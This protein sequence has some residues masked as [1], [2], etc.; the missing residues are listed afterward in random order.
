MP[1][2]SLKTNRKKNIARKD[3]CFRILKR[4]SGFAVACFLVLS[5]SAFAAPVAVGTAVGAARGW[6]H[7][8]PRPLGVRL[9]SKV[10]IAEEVKS[11]AG[12]TLF[13]AVQLDP[14]GFVIIAADDSTDPV[15]VFTGV[16]AFHS[17]SNG[18]LADLVKRDMLRRI[19][20]ARTE[21]GAAS[22]LKSRRKWQALLRN[23]SGLTHFP[24]Q[25]PDSVEN[26]EGVASQIWIAPFVQT[27]WSQTTD[28]SGSNAC[29]NYFTPPYAAGDVD[30]YDCGCSATC[31][32]QEM[33][34]FRY[35]GVS[36]GTNSFTISNNGETQMAQLRG[37]D[38]A[39]GP[40]Q[41]GEM[42]L[43]PNYPTL[44]QASA[45]GSLTY[46][47]GV[48]INMA[49]GPYS[50]TAD[51]SLISRALTN[52][53]KFGN[54]V[55]CVGDLANTNWVTMI[56]PNLDAR[57]PVLLGLQGQ[58]GHV[59]VCD[60]YGYSASTL[61]HH[62]N[63]GWA[64]DDDI[65]YALPNVDTA[66][67]GDFSMVEE[68][69]YNI[70]TNG[71]GQIISGRVTVPSG[72]PLVGAAVTAVRN[73]GGNYQTTTDTNG[74]YA[75]VFV[76]ADSTYSLTA[77]KAGYATAAYYT[78]T[79]SS[80]ND[81]PASGNVWG[82]N[83]VLSPPL[84]VAPATGF[85][86]SG[87]PGGPF[88]VPSEIYT[89]TNAS[90]AP[91]NW[92]LSNDS[93]WLSVTPTS[94]LLAAGAFS[95]LTIALSPAVNNLFAG[96][97]S[98]SIW[99][100]NLNNRAAEEL[101]FSLAV[102]AG[103]APIAVTGY[104][105]DV[106]VQNTA[107]AGNST[108]YAE[109]FD[110]FFPFL[111]PPGPI[112]FYEAG[113]AATNLFGETAALG[114]PPGRLF[115][116]RVDNATTFQFGPY[117]ADNV[118]YLTT[119]AA[120]ASLAFNPPAAY[121]SLSVL[122]ASAQSGGDGTLVLQFSDGTA[123]SAIPFD[124]AN[125]LTT[126]GQ[127][128]NAAITNFGLLAV[129]DFGQFYSLNLFDGPTVTPSLFQ[130]SINLQD[131]AYDTNV[132]MSVLFTMPGGGEAT[133]N[134]VTGIFAL[135]GTETSFT[136][137]YPLTVGA[138]P[139]AGGTVSGGGIFAA[140]S[141]TTLTAVAS[142]AYSFADW[143]Q[144]G[145]AVSTSPIYTLVV[146]S[147]ETLV[148]NFLP[149]CLLTLT[150]FPA[151]SGTIGGGGPCPVGSYQTVMATPYSGFQFIGWS[152][153][154]SGTSNP[155]TIPVNQNMTITAN[156]AATGTAL[157]L[158]VTT[159]GN[160]TVLP[161]LNGQILQAGKNYTLTAT[162]AP[163]NLFSNWSG[164]ITTLQNPLTIKAESN[165]VLQAN[166]VPNPFTP[167]TG[168]Y[169][170]L[171]MDTN[172]VTL[173]SSGSFTATLGNKGVFTANLVLAGKSYPFSGQFSLTGLVSN[174]VTLAGSN[175]LH[176]L[177]QLDLEGSDILTGTVGNGVWSADLLAYR[178]KQYPLTETEQYTIAISGNTTSATQPGGDG[179]G[180]LSINSEGNGTFSGTLADNTAVT[181]TAFISP[182]GLWPLY[183]SLYSGK[184]MIIGWLSLTNDSSIDLDG[185]V[186]WVKEHQTGAPYYGTGFTNDCQVFGSR[187]AYTNDYP[188]LGLTNDIFFLVG[189]NLSNGLTNEITL[190]GNKAVSTNA[191][192]NLT[193]SP[194][195][196]TFQGTVANPV[197]GNLPKTLSFKGV[198]LQK[199]NVAVGFCLGTNQ[200]GF[201]GIGS[202]SIDFAQIRLKK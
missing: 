3:S 175:A 135:S 46:D 155:L 119:G 104:N 94:G 201:A 197:T 192:L 141:T 53:F 138:A 69:C 29:Y 62:L 5:C 64:G 95:D 125:Y 167:V 21:A 108:Y 7:H 181:E 169:E 2:M 96:T 174:Y 19:A 176:V 54:A 143:T 129:G 80:V 101:S 132:I 20:K 168:V 6:L 151:G 117:N 147:N 134:A 23:P 22:A 58:V 48:A 82:A 111:N 130:T 173:E 36:V 73:G 1:K 91:L 170:G 165:M 30:N 100:T 142:G 81:V 12:E 116:S 149:P 157:T 72:A 17:A 140:G 180:F 25:I 68:V 115:T 112:C 144:G 87:P 194:A 28:A 131:Y 164:T 154:A 185:A 152:G 153:E 47:A 14:S 156:F 51:G 13:Y 38:G 184:G 109:A 171:Y 127:S 128:T 49:Y 150:G 10:K 9:P 43:S 61:F 92:A 16:G 189:G 122:A 133:S 148:A 190:A 88:S 76:P 84:L 63:M 56:N 178:A 8:D 27:L 172:D 200:C 139:A 179:F 77:T 55:Y 78:A 113:L 195:A 198:A 118:L 191:T 4:F 26:G 67:N 145:S 146:N 74:I 24:N 202:N 196:G 15:V 45:I 97:Y 71:S 188:I 50:S 110:P 105:R 103:D 85:A 41:W 182:T 163:G 124:A 66:D 65:W 44:V 199:A 160:G 40:Y 183:V 159:N 123:S 52:T 102:N 35:P 186:I 106:V 137:S 193:F 158:I 90:T 75:L 32:A 37:G 93:T 79:G 57:L 121:K 42:P 161:N 31:M 89:L 70:Y 18:P 162:A 177:L 33:F 126:N 86:S 114:L 34:Y 120:S 39:G 136:P 166:F 60:G 11:A 83:F 187:Y 59:S 107:V 99:I 98:A